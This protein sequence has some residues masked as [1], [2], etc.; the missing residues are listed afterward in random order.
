MKKWFRYSE[1]FEKYVLLL[2]SMVGFAALLHLT[3]LTYGKD[4]SMFQTA[5]LYFAVTVW[6]AIAGMLIRKGMKMSMGK[7]G[8]SI[9]QDA[10]E[11]TKTTEG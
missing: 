4:E 7:D 11:E 6:L 9:S 3:Y 8:V 2:M 5:L 10:P 1:H